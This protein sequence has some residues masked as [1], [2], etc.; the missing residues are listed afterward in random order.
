MTG[1]SFYEGESI[2]WRR[3]KE[4]DQAEY[5]SMHEAALNF[6]A[7][8]L[9]ASSKQTEEKKKKN[10]QSTL[11]SRWPSTRYQCQALELFLSEA[12]DPLWEEKEQ[13][14]KIFLFWTCLLLWSPGSLTC[15]HR[16]CYIS[17]KKKKM[18]FWSGTRGQTAGRHKGSTVGEQTLTKSQPRGFCSLV[19]RQVVLHRVL[20]SPEWLWVKPFVLLG[21]GGLLWPYQT[22]HKQVK[23]K[24]ILLMQLKWKF[25]TG[26]YSLIINYII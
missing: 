6:L 1:D 14:K 9:P 20:Y 19:Q 2:C 5:W 18:S 26:F 24:V 10:S 16:Q 17:F 23:A 15:P 3:P 25:T 4:W 11:Q 12:H 22:L 13:K 8:K 21:V 7:I